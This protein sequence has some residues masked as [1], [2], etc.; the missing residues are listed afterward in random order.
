MLHSREAHEIIKP[1]TGQLL[2]TWEGNK[3]FGGIFII[4]VLYAHV[5]EVGTLKGNLMIRIEDNTGKLFPPSSILFH[6]KLSML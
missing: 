4:S 1:G 3:F 2:A 5:H 6:V